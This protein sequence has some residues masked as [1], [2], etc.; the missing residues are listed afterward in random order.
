M[1]REH[2]RRH[3]AFGQGPHFCAG[4]ALARAEGRIGY[5]TLLRR[6]SS[7]RLATDDGAGG[8][9]CEYIPSMSIR[10]QKFLHIEF[11]KA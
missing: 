4:A 1:H 9:A 6:L 10:M 11:D 5:E 3:L 7:I 2:V 8:P